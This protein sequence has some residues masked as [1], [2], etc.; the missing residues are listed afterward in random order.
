M[1]QSLQLCWVLLISFHT[2][3]PCHG[4]GAED[5]KKRWKEY[6]ELYKKTLMNQITTQMVWSVAQ[7][8]TFWTVKSKLGLRKLLS[9]KLVD[10]MEFSKVI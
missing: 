2:S 7:S 4:K 5:I 1:A 9:N 6:R 10:A 8:Q 3:L